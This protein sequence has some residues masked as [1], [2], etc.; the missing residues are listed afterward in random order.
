MPRHLLAALTVLALAAAPLALATPPAR[1]QASGPGCPDTAQLDVPGAELEQAVCLDDLTTRSNERTDTGASTGAGTRG[2]GSLHASSTRLTQEPV[3]GVQVEG[4]F[5]DSCAHFEV[6][7]NTFMPMCAN[8]LRHNGQFVIRVPN[9]WDGEHLVV[10]GTPGLR[11]QF[12]SDIILSDFVLARGW[13]YASQDKGNTGLNFFR[14]G[15]DE[16]GGSRTEWIP[17]RAIEQWAPFMELTALA[18]KGTLEQ[19]HGAPPSLTYAAG[20]SNGGYQTR[21][22]LERYPELFEGG[23]DWEGTLLI[24]EA[25]NLFTYIPPLLRN[26]P[27]YKGGSEQ[28]Y[29]AMVHQG[30][31]PP[32]SEPIWDNH[33]SIYWG[34]VQSTYRPVYDPEYTEYVATPREVLPGDPDAEYEY[35]ERPA[36]VAERIAETA[37]TGDLNGKPLITLHGTLDALLPI[38][39]DS[40]VYA[41]MVRASDEGENHRYYV[42]ENGTH[43]DKLADSYPQVFQ[44]ILPCFLDA[45][46]DLD[47]WV[48]E[49]AAPAPSGFVPFAADRTPEERANRCDLPPP[50]DRAA[51]GDRIETALAGSRGAFG[52]TET[53]TVA[54]A[55]D[56]TDALVAAPLAARLGG[57]VLLVG[58]ELTDGLRRELQRL[59]ALGAV[60][61]GGPA[62]VGEA[63]VRELEAEGLEVRRVGGDD[64]FATAAAVA[65]EVGLPEGGEVIVTTGER[66]PDALSISPVAAAAGTPILLTGRDALPDVTAQTIRR[67]G[68]ESTLVVGGREAVSDAVAEALPA[69]ARAAGATRYGTSVAV[70][71][72]A[73]GRGHTLEQLGIATGLNFPDALTAA[74][75]VLEGYGGGAPRGVVLL[76]DGEDPDG[77]PETYEYLSRRR[78]EVDQLLVFGGREAVSPAVVGRLAPEAADATEP[79]PG[80][81]TGEPGGDPGDGTGDGG[82]RGD[83]GDE[84][85]AGEEIGTTFPP[86]FPVIEDASLGTPVLGFGAQ[87]PVS[88]TPVILLHGN[89]DTPYPT[90]CNG[91]YGHIHDLAQALADRGYA[92]AELWGLGYQGDQCDLLTSPTNRS[93]EAH[94]TVANVPDL[95]AFVAAV[96]DY[97]G[98]EQVDIVGHSLGATLPRE[99]MRQDD[100]YDLV[101][102]LVSLDGP[103]HGIINCSPSPANYY[104]QPVSGG[105]DPDSAICREYGAAD[106]P[107]LAALNGGDETPGPTEYL[108][109]RNA[110]TSFV[111]FPEQDGVFPPVPSEDRH[112][113][114]HD[115]TASAALEGAELL[116]VTGQGVHDTATGTAHIGISSS[117]EVWEAAFDFL[118]RP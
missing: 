32:D 48:T 22:A 38:S 112:G 13:A 80:I 108:A 5:P 97:T 35:G 34:L 33:W 105:F 78:A 10:A 90:D 44:P 114:P 9:D 100:A 55:G 72:L 79:D 51:G 12:A 82:D 86:D 117:P 77:S 14:A 1:A 70:A 54:S 7:N 91:A 23:L 103:H 4:W 42:V 93:G 56:Y 76:V 24:P 116:D 66:F 94:S 92:A 40:D 16:T 81:D 39:T 110:D 3:P 115:F 49:G 31:V 53:V 43:V 109:V 102:R 107:L 6:E 46:D 71:E 96:L 64:R 11:T 106:T 58:D 68:A 45:I 104:Q 101:R 47:A 30:R 111:Y 75:V 25:P 99:W 28:A 19:L 8:G 67:L 21:I 18:A 15:D 74:P 95:R 2:N 57:P 61:V 84:G 62:V 52:I 69:P 36:F 17:G 83:G 50:V 20:I 63:V 60:I 65:E 59:G 85:G 26:Y 37:N 29:E 87:G 41:E 113:E 73:L 89:N 118:A 88:R 98:A 27:D